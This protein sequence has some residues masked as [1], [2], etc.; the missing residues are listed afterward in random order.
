MNKKLGIGVIGLGRLGSAYAKYFTGRIAGAT[1]VAV[2]DVIES[3][4][5]S[6]AAELGISKRYG[7]YQDL[8]ADAEVEGVVVVS[9]TSTHKEIVLEA[10]KH[11]KAIFC[12]KPLSISLDTAHEMLRVI[13]QTGVFFQMG[14]MR[15]FDKGY[16]G[17]KRKLEDGVIGT[18]VV[19]KSSSR[20]PY[21]PSLE[22]L[23]PAHSGGLFIDCGIHD[24]DLAR[25]YMGEIASVYSIGGTLAYPEMK[26][27]GDIDNA[28]TSLYFTSG[29]LGTIDLSRNGV[30]GYDIRTEILGT[31]G[32][33]KIGYLRETP[34]LVMTKDGITHDT[35]P[36]FTERFEQAYITQVQDFVNNVL[37]GKL[38]SVSCADGVAALQ[39]S[40][41]ATLS[42]KEN[43][44]VKIEGDEFF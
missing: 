3:T 36:Y 37:Q 15:R 28:I 16:V 21:R 9:P 8:I 5:T 18:P 11:G 19:F 32:T 24:L 30:Y 23:D 10:A 44:P 39:V 22:Y 14:F 35:V 20:D 42:F 1:L 17:A 13:E 43:R 25:W 2:S 41:A 6:V 12:E 29:A 38:P 33:L 27:I 26:E 40:A 4:V 7:R 34:I 31:E